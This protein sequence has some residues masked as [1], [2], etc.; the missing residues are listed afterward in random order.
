MNKRKSEISP[1]SPKVVK[2]DKDT[3]INQVES[4]LEN[5]LRSPQRKGI[6]VVPI[7]IYVWLYR[8][9]NENIE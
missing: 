8:L 1:S 4:K 5:I 2:Q 3:N 7:G 9:Y 6:K